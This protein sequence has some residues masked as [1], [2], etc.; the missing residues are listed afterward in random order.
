[1]LIYFA[2]KSSNDEIKEILT[3][4][5][6]CNADLREEATNTIVDLLAKCI[7]L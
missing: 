1:M 5:R 3:L 4:D 2:A 7:L 6:S